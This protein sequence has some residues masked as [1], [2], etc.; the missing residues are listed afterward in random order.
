MRVRP[1]L[2]AG[3][4]TLAAPIAIH[5]AN[6]PMGA[7][8]ALA[9]PGRPAEDKARDADRKPAEMLAVAQVRP[10]QTVIDFIPGKGYFTRLFSAAVGPKGHVFAVTPQFLIDK[11]KAAGKPVPPPVSQEPGR[12]NVQEAVSGGGTLG[13]PDGKADLVWTSQNY[14][15]V[16]IFTGAEGTAALNK[17]VYAALKPGGLYVVEDHAG[18]AG[19][20]EAGMKQL[21]RID[22]ALVKKEV[23][24]AGF[25]LDGESQ[26]LRN[27][28]DPHTANVFDPAIRGKT[29]QFV[30]R[31]R[32]AK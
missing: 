15:D 18:S 30:L 6:A 4:A 28:D 7:A 20:D 1:L 11:L 25:V 5:A 3:L 9:D 24:A 8:A 13:V 19:L 22:E 26:V 32:K 31:F 12:A 21:H 14:H 2:L 27:A 16:R 23:I 10:G 29:D 17:A